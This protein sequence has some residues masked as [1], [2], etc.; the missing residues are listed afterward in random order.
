MATLELE[1]AQV[2]LAVGQLLDTGPLIASRLELIDRLSRFFG[3]VVLSALV[4]EEAEGHFMSGHQ[5]HGGAGHGTP[6]HIH[7]GLIASKLGRAGQRSAVDR[8][9]A[10]GVATTEGVLVKLELA[11]VI[12]G[13]EPAK[14]SAEEPR[15]VAARDREIGVRPR[16]AHRRGEGGVVERTQGRVVL[17][18][19][20]QSLGTR[21]LLGG[22]APRTLSLGD[23]RRIDEGLRGQRSGTII[24]RPEI[25]GATRNLQEALV[26]RGR[27]VEPGSG[28][29]RGEALGWEG[30]GDD[31][32]CA[33]GKSALK[34]G[35]EGLADHH[36]VDHGCG[37]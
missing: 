15:G 25:I 9:S 21:C 36:P 2:A 8:I 1:V 7:D 33:A 23:D 5:L 14:A 3:D 18:G 22:V 4:V 12:E 34:I 32:H 20:G 27:A 17:L 16:L 26:H 30:F 37:D 11:I 10:V 28:G 29:D 13:S 6:T 24:H 19:Q 31:V 35:S